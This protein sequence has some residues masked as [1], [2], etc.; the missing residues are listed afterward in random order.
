M[1]RV[2]IT[3][4]LMIPLVLALSGC[5]ED[6]T[7][8]IVL[9]SNSCIDFDEYS[10]SVNWTSTEIVH[11]G[12]DLDDIRADN[13]IGLDEVDS[14][15]VSGITYNVIAFN[16]A[17]PAW[18]VGGEITVERTDGAGA[19]PVVL[20][21]YAD[22]S[23]PDEYVSGPQVVEP[24]PAGVAL[25]NDALYDY[26]NGT[27]SPVLE[28]TV[29]NGSVTPAPSAADPIDFTWKV[30][31]IVQIIGTLDAEVIVWLGGS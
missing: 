22:L 11:M 4:A 5:L 23:I 3:A 12:D 30:C 24:Q 17:D 2:L 10:E 16:L 7:L 25:I 26:L 8:Q 15:F 29:N 20:F 18:V 28:L 31:V 27:A 14:V 21:E 9:S 1:K 6:R 19:G 13:D